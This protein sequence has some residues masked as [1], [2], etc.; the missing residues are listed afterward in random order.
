MLAV[1]ITFVVDGE[2]LVVKEEW[3]V[4]YGTVPVGELEA[5]GILLIDRE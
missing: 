3:R 1:A 4:R 5:A 2:M